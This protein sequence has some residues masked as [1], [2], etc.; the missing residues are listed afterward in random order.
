MFEIK[1]SM[2]DIKQSMLEIK[3]PMLDTKQSMLEIKQSMFLIKESMLLIHLNDLLKLGQGMNQCAIQIFREITQVTC[4]FCVCQ[5]LDES[6]IIL[7]RKI[8]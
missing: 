2:F 7:F 3:L 5:G 1:R 6:G 4:H 8:I